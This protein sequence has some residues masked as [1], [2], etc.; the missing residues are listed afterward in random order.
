ME[1][2]TLWNE[3]NN[4]IE[5]EMTDLSA[6]YKK[7]YEVAENSFNKHEFFYIAGYVSYNR[8]LDPQHK[9]DAILCFTKS[10]CYKSGYLPS[11]LYLAYIYVDYKNYNVALNLLCSFDIQ[12]LQNFPDEEVRFYEIQV[13]TL[14]KCNLWNLALEKLMVFDIFLKKDKY[15]GIDLINFIWLADNIS[16]TNS[17]EEAVMEK[18]KNIITYPF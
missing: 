3:I 10:L 16:P 12:N 2:E 18:I 4:A 7:L 8:V 1:I 14:I 6:L 5:H 11:I 9:E 15:C 13:F 17:I